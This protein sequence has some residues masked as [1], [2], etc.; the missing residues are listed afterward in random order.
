ML[1]NDAMSSLARLLLWQPITRIQLGPRATAVAT[2]LTPASNPGSLSHKGRR[3]LDVTILTVVTERLIWPD[4]GGR[5]SPILWYQTLQAD[6]L[7]HTPGEE[8]I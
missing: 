2:F 6:T 3:S 7:W 8:Q 4:G 1:L 5:S